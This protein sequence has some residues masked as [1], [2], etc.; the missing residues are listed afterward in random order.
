MD[1]FVMM[2]FGLMALLVLWD[3]FDDFNNFGGGNNF[4]Y[5]E[6]YDEFCNGV[7]YD[8]HNKKRSHS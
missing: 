2:V 1:V 3:Y 7:R 6:T 4:G 5:W 8:Y